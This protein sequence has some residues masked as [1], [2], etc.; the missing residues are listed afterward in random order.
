MQKAKVEMSL[1][2]LKTVTQ[3]HR[4][5]EIQKLRL[6]IEAEIHWANVRFNELG[7]KFQC[8][9]KEEGMSW[10]DLTTQ[11]DT[12]YLHFR[13][14]MLMAEEKLYSGRD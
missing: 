3:R 13:K 4:V 8:W 9:S 14:S 12:V 5:I 11:L 1:A 2:S 7:K 10:E 6:K